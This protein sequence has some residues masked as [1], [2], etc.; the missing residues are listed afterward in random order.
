[1]RAMV[2]GAAGFVGSH[3][4][5]ALTARGDDVVA[6]ERPGAARGWLR[7]LDVEFLDCGLDHQD[8]LRRALGGVE[9]VFHLAAVTEARRPADCY[10]VNTRGKANV[11]RAMDAAAHG[12]RARRLVGG[13]GA[14]ARVFVAESAGRRGACRSA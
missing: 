4:V 12:G 13:T 11:V 9:V 8:R 14:R 7:G 2:T 6:V 5:E 1:M 10:A 3:L